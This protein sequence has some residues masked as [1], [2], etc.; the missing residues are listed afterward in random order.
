MWGAISGPPSSTRPAGRNVAAV[1]RLLEIVLGPVLPELADARVGRDHGVLQ[2]PADALH[3]AD[4]DVLDGV[5]V[6][7]DRERAARGV[8]DLHL[9]EGGQERGALLHLAADGPD[10]L[11]DPAHVR[12]RRLA[13][14]GRDLAGTGIE[15][16]GD[17]PDL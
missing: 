8:L 5:A 4:V 7:V 2:S 3:P 9:A 11:G 1:E 16:T 12:V 15:R 13:V 6:G 10:G 17:R 14:V